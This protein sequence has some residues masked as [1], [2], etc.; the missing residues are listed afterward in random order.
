MNSYGEVYLLTNTLDGKQYVGQTRV[1]H[2]GNGIIPKRLK[3]KYGNDVF[4]VEILTAADS[5]EVLDFWESWYITR[6]STI[7]PHGFNLQEGGRGG[8]HHLETR[9]KM[10]RSRIGLKNAKGSVRS[11]EFRENASRHSKLC[12]ANG[13]HTKGRI[14]TE[15][16]KRKISEGLLNSTKVRTISPEGLA[17]IKAAGAA[18]RGRRPSEETRMKLSAAAK[19]RK[20]SPEATAKRLASRLANKLSRQAAS[21]S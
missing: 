5:Q 15:E 7:Y 2:Y 16:H 13:G 20:P 9:T 1:Q 8:K 12:Q 6:L 17:R 18:R 3:K 21:Q 11:K 14:L 19:G 10:G 4:T